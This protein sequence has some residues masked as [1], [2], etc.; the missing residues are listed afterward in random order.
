MEILGHSQIALTMNTYSHVAPEISR[1]AAD[2]IA[3]T[4]W[5]CDEDQA[6]EPEAGEYEDGQG[7]TS[8]RVAARLASWLASD[9]SPV[10]LT[11]DSVGGAPGARTQNPR[12]KSQ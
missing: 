8:D 6:D 10:P 9:T 2:R 7:R 4:L 5:Q 1:E 3:E 11:L 12:I